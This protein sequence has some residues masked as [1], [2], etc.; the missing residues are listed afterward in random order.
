MTKRLKIFGVIAALYLGYSAIYPDYS[1]R[2]RLELRVSVDG[3]VVADS[4]VIE[5][6]WRGG[7]NIAE[8]FVYTAHGSVEGRAPI[9]DLKERGVVVA[10]LRTNNDYARSA[11]FFGAT[12]FGNDSSYKALPKLGSLSG[13]RS[14]APNGWPTLLWFP[15]SASPDG[16]RVIDRN[17]PASILGKGAY[18][19]SVNVETTNASVTTDVAKRLPW[20]WDWRNSARS[21]VLRPNELLLTPSMLLGGG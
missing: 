4:S 11:L 10:A 5:V 21:N 6:T 2:Y 8:H 9:V 3:K 12:A 20:F 14:L 7:P 1:Y 16:V 18:D 13:R 15:S 17:D 19:I